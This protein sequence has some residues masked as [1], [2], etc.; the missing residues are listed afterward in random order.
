MSFS[1][2]TLYNCEF[3]ETGKHKSGA[4]LARGT[5]CLSKVITSMTLYNR[6]NVHKL[7]ARVM[8]INYYSVYVHVHSN[9]PGTRLHAGS[10][11]SYNFNYISKVHYLVQVV[12][13]DARP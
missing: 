7:N 4:S 13:T 12:A 3:I 9:M 8:Y 11:K 5:A 1:E 2:C 6:M 10:R